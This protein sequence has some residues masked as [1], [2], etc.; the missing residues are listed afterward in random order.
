M[1]AEDG[2]AM[3]VAEAARP[4]PAKD[5]STAMR[6]LVTRAWVESAGVTAGTRA[7]FLLVALAA[8]WFLSTETQGAPQQSFLSLWD[9]W[10]AHH[11]VTIGEH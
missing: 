5:G 6:S 1:G 7:A 9:N 2:L 4:A 11:L 3:G 8:S 10:D